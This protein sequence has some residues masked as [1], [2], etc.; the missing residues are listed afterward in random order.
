MY[1]INYSLN[2]ALDLYGKC[3]NDYPSFFTILIA[4]AVL[5]V[6]FFANLESGWNNFKLTV[7]IETACV[8]FTLYY[9]GLDIVNH[10][11][12]ALNGN[13]MNNICFFFINTNI[14]LIILGSVFSTSS[15][16]YISK[17]ILMI[18]YIL[19]LGNLIFALFITYTL[20]QEIF[21][22][23]GN[24]AP[25]I[26]IGNFIAVAS[27]IILI[28]LLCSNRVCKQFANK[29]HLLYR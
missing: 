6:V 7:I 13:F 8:F 12:T 29:S 27:Y 3:I 21:I 25:M 19:L 5:G 23:L 24:I 4:M 26:I 28:I 2:S 10:F 18:F 20:N 9:F 11:D 17:A 15:I 16:E 22:T 14:A 1:N